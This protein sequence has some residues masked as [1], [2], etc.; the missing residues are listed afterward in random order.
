MADW[1]SGLTELTD[2]AGIIVHDQNDRAA[3][4]KLENAFKLDQPSRSLVALGLHQQLTLWQAM[5]GK[6]SASQ[7]GQPYRPPGEPHD[8]VVSGQF[9]RQLGAVR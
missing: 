8:V 6:P 9:M 2:D 3:L 5:F 1:K 7:L 4:L